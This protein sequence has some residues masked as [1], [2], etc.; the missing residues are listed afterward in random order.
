M[1][2]NVLADIKAA[3]IAEGRRRMTHWAPERHDMPS[4]S[5]ADLGE[6]AAEAAT[7]S[8]RAEGGV[9]NVRINNLPTEDG[10]RVSALV[11]FDP[12]AL[13][14]TGAR[15]D[16]KRIKSSNLLASLAALGV[17]IKAVPDDVDLEGVDMSEVK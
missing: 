14:D 7:P 11:T 12:S 6:F 16:P 2:S 9:R 10:R 5:L 17:G 4:L 8:P 15:F 3:R 13:R 1:P